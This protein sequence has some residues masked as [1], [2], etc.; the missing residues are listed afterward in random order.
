VDV[1]NRAVILLLLGTGIRLNKLSNIQL[2]DIDFDRE[3]VRIYG[4]GNKERIVRIGKNTQ[5]TLLH[6]L[7]MRH[8][9]YPCLWLNVSR[10]PVSRD[11]IQ[12]AVEK[13]CKRAGITNAKP[14]PHTFRHTAAIVFLRNGGDSS[15]LQYMLGHS[16]LTLNSSFILNLINNLFKKINIMVW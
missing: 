12:T 8:D 13:L 7:L 9:E 10:R 5:K 4:K 6:Y 16:S 11:G 14:G 15:I 1:R 2:K 3:T